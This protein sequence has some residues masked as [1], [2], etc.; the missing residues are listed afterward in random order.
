MVG[1]LRFPIGAPKA[2]I[3]YFN[4]SD[5]LTMFKDRGDRLEGSHRQCIVP[6]DFTLRLP[7]LN[8]FCKEHSLNGSPAEGLIRMVPGA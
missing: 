8:P 3:V 2:E 6:S 7:P 4:M 1:V 5:L